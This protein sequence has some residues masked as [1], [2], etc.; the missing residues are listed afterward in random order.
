MIS[1]LFFSFVQ[2]GRYPLVAVVLLHLV[3]SSKNHRRCRLKQGQVAALHYIKQ[4]HRLHLKEFDAVYLSHQA[5]FG[6]T[7]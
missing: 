5:L 1:A 4:H 2:C 7:L 3:T 6:V